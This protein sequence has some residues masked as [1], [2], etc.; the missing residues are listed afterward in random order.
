MMTS[1][2]GR[3]VMGSLR[4]PDRYSDERCSREVKSFTISSCFRQGCS[5][6][7]QG[8]KCMGS[9]AS[10]SSFSSFAV[11]AHLKFAQT[12][13]TLHR[14]QILSAGSDAMVALLPRQKQGCKPR[15]IAGKYAHHSAALPITGFL[16][17]AYTQPRP[18]AS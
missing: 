3:P 6:L 16:V 10:S 18:T 9:R 1:M 4:G 8:K 11:P 17:I 14:V 13:Y 12:P 2:S 15:I 7:M 5:Q